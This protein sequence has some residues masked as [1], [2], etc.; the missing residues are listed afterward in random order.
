[1][2]AQKLWSKLQR[3]LKELSAYIEQLEDQIATLQSD[4]A[5]HEDRIESLVATNWWLQIF[6]TAL[7]AASN[8]EEDH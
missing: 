5:L 8:D 2:T 1:M 3:S 6:L 4:N 7:V